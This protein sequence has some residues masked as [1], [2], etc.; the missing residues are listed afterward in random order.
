MRQRAEQRPA[1]Q[2]VEHERQRRTT[3][4]GP[5]PVRHFWPVLITMVSVS[6]TA[7]ADAPCRTPLTAGTSLK[8][9]VQQRQHQ[10]DHHGHEAQADDRRD[11]AGNGPHL[12]AGEHRHVDLVG[13]GQDSAHR[14]GGQELL[15]AHPLLLD[16]DHLAR[17]R[18]QP[19]AERRQRDVVERPRQARAAR[20]APD[21]GS[22]PQRP[23]L[24]H[25]FGVV[26]EVVLVM[27]GRVER[28]R[29]LVV[30]RQAAS[31]RRRRTSA[32]RRRPASVI[33][34]PSSRRRSNALRSMFIEPT[35][36]RSS[37][38]ISSLAC[39][40]RFFCL[41]TL[42]PNR[43]NVRSEAKVSST[44][45]VA[46]AVPAAAQHVHLHA[47]VGGC[48]DVVEDHRVDV[49]GML[50]VEPVR[51][52]VDEPGHVQPRVGVAPQQARR[53]AP[54]PSRRDSSRR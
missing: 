40:R 30:V 8:R 13:A 54:A 43:R 7:A 46:D 9:E 16:D 11:G 26:R 45:H 35:S 14:H 44:S 15:L 21:C 24:M 10:H 32:A 5:T 51:G 29:R 3:R 53:S 2:A 22:A 18:G 25:E 52:G 20:P 23:S 4:P 47:A 39:T 34:M 49:L 33:V 31:P 36:A 50:N 38:T 12:G 6:A 1:Q 17:P 37:S 27:R 41:C 42:T 19:A 28:I 48:R